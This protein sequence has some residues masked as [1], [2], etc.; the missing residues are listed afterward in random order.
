LKIPL[1]VLYGVVVLE[2]HAAAARGKLAVLG[3]LKTLRW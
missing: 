1:V 3:L 2:L